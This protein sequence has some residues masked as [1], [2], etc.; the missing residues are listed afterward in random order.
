MLSVSSLIELLPIIF[1][2]PGVKSFLSDCLSQ[3]PLEKFLA[4][5]GNVVVLQLTQMYIT[6]VR[7]ARLCESLILPV[8]KFHA[9]IAEDMR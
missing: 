4:A 1:F 2:I 9:L 6:F 3:D 5:N 8:Q 7:I